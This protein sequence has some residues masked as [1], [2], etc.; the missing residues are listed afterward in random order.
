LRT[1]LQA[2]SDRRH[3]DGHKKWCCIGERC[4]QSA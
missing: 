2:D 1:F 4:I 3:R